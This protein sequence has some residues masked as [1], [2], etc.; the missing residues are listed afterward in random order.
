[1]I[2]RI[3]ITIR[4]SSITKVT[5]KTTT[6]IRTRATMDSTSRTTMDNITTRIR[7]MAMIISSN[8]TIRLSMVTKHNNTIKAVSRKCRITREFRPKLIRSKRNLITAAI[9]ESRK[10]QKK[11]TRIRICRIKIT[12]ISKK[13]TTKVVNN[14]TTDMTTISS[15][16]NSSIINPIK[17]KT[18]NIKDRINKVLIQEIKIKGNKRTGRH[19]WLVIWQLTQQSRI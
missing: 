6:I 17:A 11:F 16:L 15:K 18:T 5:T 14:N 19:R 12:P 7:V 9:W 1:M 3:T 10:S 8:I 2:S 4:T 13:V